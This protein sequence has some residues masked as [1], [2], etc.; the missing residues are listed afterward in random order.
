MADTFCYCWE[1]HEV[2]KGL[3]AFFL[4]VLCECWL[5]EQVNSDHMEDIMEPNENT[6]AHHGFAQIYEWVKM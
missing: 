1:I 3:W 2:R 4:V 5:A 6:V